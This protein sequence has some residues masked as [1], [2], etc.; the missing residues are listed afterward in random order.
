MRRYRELSEK[1]IKKP[2][3]PVKEM[4]DMERM[5]R[6]AKPALA[7]PEK[8]IS[9]SYLSQSPREGPE[10]EKDRERQCLEVILRQA[11][12]TTRYTYKQIWNYGEGN[13]AGQMASSVKPVTPTQLVT[14]IDRVM[15]EKQGRMFLVNREYGEEPEASASVMGAVA[16][17]T[18]M[19]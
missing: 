1:S 8:M 10:D 2:I 13:G 16:D 4:P 6:E 15:E 7:D 5:R 11:D 14:D 3:G 18:A 17:R 19:M 9:G 12:G